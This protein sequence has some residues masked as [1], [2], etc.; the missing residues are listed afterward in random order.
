MK[1]KT[2]N[3]NKLQTILCVIALTLSVLISAV[4]FCMFPVHAATVTPKGSLILE[5]SSGDYLST[6]YTSYVRIYSEDSPPVK[7]ASLVR[8]DDIVNGDSATLDFVMYT[9]DIDASFT[10][11]TGNETQYTD[12]SKSPY[13]SYTEFSSSHMTIYT[14]SDGSK[15]RAMT[16]GLGRKCYSITPYCPMYNGT[17]EYKSLSGNDQI[18]AFLEHLLITGDINPVNGSNV[19]DTTDEAYTFTGFS[20]N[21][22]TARWTGTTERSYLK[23]QEV[24]EYTTITYAWATTTEPDN[25]GEFQTYN[26]EFP[27]SD[28][29]LKLPWADMENNKNDNEFIRQVNLIPCYRVP[30][31]FYHG[32]GVKVFY[33]SDGTIERTEFIKKQ[34]DL[35]TGNMVYDSSIGYLQNVIYTEE[36][37]HD[38]KG[39]QATFKWSTSKSMPTDA[40]VEIVAKNFYIEWFNKTT[41]ENFVYKEYGEDCIY[42]V[43]SYSFNANTPAWTWL[44]EKDIDPFSVKTQSYGTK[45]YY[46]RIITYNDNDNMYHYGGWVRVNV[47]TKDSTNMPTTD[48]ETGGFDDNSGLWDKDLDS[49]DSYHY[50]TDDKGNL[51]GDIDIDSWEDLNINSFTWLYRNLQSMTQALG[52]LPSMI[53]TIFGFLPSQVITALSVLLTAVVLMRFLGR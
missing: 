52:Q 28:K 32:S 12:T 27:T 9:T 33:K 45:E 53:S 24:E 18:Q 3:Q 35:N 38:G 29:Q 43:G 47:K 37:T 20:I 25:I 26:G 13:T 15:V 34:T 40:Q 1:Q 22:K 30:G 48:V 39:R 46:L 4:L 19:P 11:Y 49:D 50:S 51:T 10:F 17:S 23:N 36:K 16:G 14:L 5:S 7:F 8:Y 2:I 21:G 44:N 41:E 31:A 6:A 42:S